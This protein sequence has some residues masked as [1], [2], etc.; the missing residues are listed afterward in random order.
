MNVINDSYF[1]EEKGKVHWNAGESQTVLPGET[2]F[3]N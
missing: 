1:D 2:E 3:F